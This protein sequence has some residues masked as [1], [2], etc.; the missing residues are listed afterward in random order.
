MITPGMIESIERHR[1]QGHSVFERGDGEYYCCTCE[2][3][4]AWHAP[5]QT[6]LNKKNNI[7]L[8]VAGA[9]Y[10]DVDSDYIEKILMEAGFRVV[11]DDNMD[12]AVQA[13]KAYFERR[14][15]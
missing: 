11:H 1:S 8:F 6:G 2:A 10:Y 13:V 14:V 7:A 4:V 3:W 15:K 5:D 12:Q 9:I